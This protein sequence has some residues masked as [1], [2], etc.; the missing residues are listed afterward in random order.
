MLTLR[1]RKAGGTWYVRGTVRVGQKS[2]IIQ[3]H[4]AGTTDAVAA[5][6]YRD[7]L[8][9]DTRLEL[10]YGAPVRPKAMTFAAAGS[11]LLD[12]RGVRGSD[13]YRL[14]RLNDFFGDY[15]TSDMDQELWSRFVAT[16]KG[17]DPNSLIKYKRLVDQA[18]AAAGLDA[19]AIKQAA[20]RHKP[21]VAWLQLDVADRLIASYESG[22]G[23]GMAREAAR[24]ARYHGLR[25]GEIVRLQKRD[26]DLDRGLMHIRETKSDE[27]RIVPIAD[28]MLLWFADRHDELGKDT[29]RLIVNRW[30][31]PY[32]DTRD[33][34][35]NPLTK[36][37]RTA[38]ATAG[39]SAFPFHGWRHHWAF[40]KVREGMDLRTLMKVG[41]WV[42]IE[43]VVVYAD[44]AVDE[45]AAEMMSRRA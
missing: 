45:R 17:K 22:K 34:G 16:L 11:L 37:H 42:E 36:A 7:R 19:P 12:A 33:K 5:R 43:M 25:A 3:E 35:G 24:I 38:C 15:A 6:E 28:A 20:K 13:S 29:D 8:Q 23:K 41:G 2:K 1:Q 44:A 21:R 31:E 32:H 4:A 18:F 14:S 9:E 30:G 26:I 39:V 27:P 40:W 10:L